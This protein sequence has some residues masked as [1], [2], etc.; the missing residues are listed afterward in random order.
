M[1]PMGHPFLEVG[2]DFHSASGHKDRVQGAGKGSKRDSG[3]FPA[4]RSPAQLCRQTPQG[5]ELCRPLS[6]PHVSPRLVLWPRELK[7]LIR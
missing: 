5:G 6:R 7:A 3:G 1:G 2:T 4:L